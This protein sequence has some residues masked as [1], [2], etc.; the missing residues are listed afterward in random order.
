MRTY[1]LHQEL[2]FGHDTNDNKLRSKRADWHLF[3]HVYLPAPLWSR[4]TFQ[5]IDLNVSSIL[6]TL[7]RTSNPF[8]SIC[9]ISFH[10]FEVF[11]LSKYLYVEWFWRHRCRLGNTSLHYITFAERAMV[12]S[13]DQAL[14]RCCRPSSTETASVF[15]NS[16]ILKYITWYSICCKKSA[17]SRKY[18]IKLAEIWT[19]KMTNLRPPSKHPCSRLNFIAPTGASDRPVCLHARKQHLN[20]EWNVFVNLWQKRYF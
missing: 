6:D 13:V 7:T 5:S 14:R 3:L 10:L 8:D 11:V 1:C 20:E 12:A 16:W 4:V 19:G 15:V 9:M 17:K 2:K 18:F